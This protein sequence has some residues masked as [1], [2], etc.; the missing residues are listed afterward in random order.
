MNVVAQI[1]H[2]ASK[3]ASPPS[4][5]LQSSNTLG[6]GVLSTT[7]NQTQKLLKFKKKTKKLLART[8]TH[9]SHHACIIAMVKDYED[10]CLVLGV[11]QQILICADSSRVG[12]M[13]I[14][15]FTDVLS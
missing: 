3:S 13:K 2:L 15:V 11:L 1:K 8:H 10:C 9:A 6:V 14:W 7:C 4:C 5:P 12:T